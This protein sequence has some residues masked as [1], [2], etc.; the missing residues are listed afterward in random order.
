MFTNIKQ[1]VS[2]F[3][4]H[5]YAKVADKSRQ[6]VHSGIK[7][8][9]KEQILRSKDIIEFGIEIIF[10]FIPHLSCGAEYV[11]VDAR[12]I[13]SSKARLRAEFQDPNSIFWQRLEWGQ[14]FAH[15]KNRRD[16]VTGRS[17]PVLVDETCSLPLRSC[18]RMEIS[19]HVMW[20]YR[21][22]A[23]LALFQW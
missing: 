15:C 5:L 20:Y 22:W 2:V 8:I 17:V 18:Y 9:K 14:N 6:W 4:E 11:L 16:V 13:W 10:K 12:N 23:L 21:F 19:S 3:Y 1:P 7:F